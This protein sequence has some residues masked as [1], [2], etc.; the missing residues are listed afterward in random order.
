[1]GLVFPCTDDSTNRKEEKWGIVWTSATLVYGLSMSKQ[2]HIAL[3]VEKQ[4]G[5]LH[6]LPFTEVADVEP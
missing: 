4:D 5:K 2:E 6:F 3:I 1:M